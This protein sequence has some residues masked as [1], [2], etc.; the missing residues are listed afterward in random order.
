MTMDPSS[1]PSPAPEPATNAYSGE[2]WAGIH[3]LY[4][5][6]QPDSPPFGIGW[7]HP[8]FQAAHANP[9]SRPQQQPQD[10]YSQTQPQQ[11]QQQQQ[12]Q[13]PQL[14]PQLQSQLQPQMVQESQQNYT[15]PAQYHINQFPQPNPPPYEASQQNTPYRQYT[16]DPQ[17]FYANSP[18]ATQNGFSQQRAVDLQR[19]NHASQ[20]APSPVRSPLPSY[21]RPVPLQNDMQNDT[22][23]L[24]N[25]FQTRHPSSA[26]HNTIDPQFLS[27]SQHSMIQPGS[28]Q[29]DFY[30][31]NPA[32]LD[33]RPAP[34]LYQAYGAEIAPRLVG[35]N[36]NFNTVQLIPQI[37]ASGKKPTKA[38]TK[39]DKP[40]TKRKKKD[41]S[42]K[43][44]ERT[45]TASKAVVKQGPR[46]LDAST[47]SDSSD[48]D[49]SSDL[50]VAPEPFPLPP[51]RPLDIEGAIKYDTLKAVW[52]PRNKQPPISTIRHA[53]TVFSELV[54]GVRDTWKAKSEIL[55][56]AENQ[57]QEDKIPE[58]KKEVILQRRLIDLI[59][60]TALD[61]GHPAII[62]RFGEHPIIVSA[63]Y[64][65]LLDRHTAADSDGPLTVNILK[66][67]TKFVTMDQAMLEKTKNDK[68]LSRFVK[69]G[70]D[71]IKQ[72]AQ[73]ILSNAAELTKRKAEIAKT[74]PK[75]TESTLDEHGMVPMNP[76]IVIRNQP[77][78]T[79]GAKRPREPETGGSPSTKR[80]VAPSN[81]KPVARPTAAA[82][83][84]RTTAT[85][86]DAKTTAAAGNTA[87]AK[88]KPNMVVPKP[89]PSLFSSLMSA[90]KKPGTSNAARAAAAAKEK[91]NPPPEKKPTPPP[92]AAPKPAFSF[93]ETM[94]DLSKP[95][96]LVASKPA[97]D[98]PPETEEERKKRLRKEERRKLRV[99]WKPDDVLTEIRLFTH[100]PEEE[101]GHDD[102]MI[103]DVADVGGEG[104]TLKLHRGMDDLDDDDDDDDPEAREKTFYP[105]TSPIEIDFS[106]LDPE[107]RQRNFL[108]RGGIQEP[109]SPEKLA[110]EQR[111][112]KTLSVFYTSPA[113]IPTS[114]KEPPAP[115]PDEAYE[116]EVPF[117]EPGDRT[118]ARSAK[119][120]AARAP[121]PQQPPPTQPQPPQSAMTP[122]N[123]NVDIASLL[124]LIQQAPQPGQPKQSQPLNPISDLEKTFGHFPTS[125]GPPTATPMLQ[126]PEAPQATQPGALPGSLDI[127][128]LLAI[129]NAQAQLQQGSPAFPPSQGQ[130]PSSS[131]APNLA[132]ILSQFQNPGA[133]VQAQAQQQP[134]SQL[135]GYNQ[136]QPKQ[137][138]GSYY[139]DADRKRMREG[140]GHG[141]KKIGGYNDYDDGGHGHGHGHGHGNKR[142]RMNGDFKHK[143]HPKAGLV[144]CRYWKEGKCLKGDDCTFRHDPLD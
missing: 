91:T 115:D 79:A 41:E 63:L 6:N 71:V 36:Q 60:T 131:Q 54:K 7:D 13:Q 125:E 52:S 45:K 113:D 69:K 86:L 35:A 20:L 3:P 30:V 144:P 122:Q 93:S 64:S 139:E 39:A 85:T 100:D 120:F 5:S 51:L 46:L 25:G 94:A 43:A 95:K 21:E 55:K 68:I 109:E 33:N 67:M 8:V 4:S 130:V 133:T 104:R 102:S 80:T 96:E 14:Q 15:L 82:A 127:Q 81:G 129:M 16:F 90:S 107:E 42:E 47:S 17:N 143:K 114:P 70:G 98:L 118:K 19:V 89:T 142:P 123:S 134:P 44:Q 62:Q 18:S 9:Q 61:G 58:I 105:Y 65:F 92:T 48:F 126:I 23:N 77:P 106:E 137:Q 59:V 66:L 11:P 132:S 97:E 128:A 74:T 121:T 135:V 37:T 87:A 75:K 34:D 108:K 103:R 57:N 28:S 40:P 110:Q 73:T 124:K 24:A 111:E 10:I 99:S 88:P 112:A 141:H 32:D 50:D 53:L 140:H 12:W 1:N 78:P 136:N 138:H 76:E 49:S 119:Y 83:T 22:I 26:Y 27:A 72:L 56:A 117:G 116:P 38:R 31:I 84:K 2:F 101:I 29:N